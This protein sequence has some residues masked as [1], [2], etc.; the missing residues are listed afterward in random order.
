MPSTVVVI[1]ALRVDFVCLF[2][3]TCPIR[4]HTFLGQIRIAHAL[5]TCIAR[6]HALWVLS[7]HRPFFFYFKST[8]LNIVWTNCTCSDM[9]ARMRAISSEHA[10]LTYLEDMFWSCTVSKC[11]NGVFC[12]DAAH[13]YVTRCQKVLKY[14]QI[15]RWFHFSIDLI[16]HVISSQN[17]ILQNLKLQTECFV[18]P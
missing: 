6:W 8:T 13:N 2:S 5:Q 16:A 1:C 7:I 10:Q 11:L 14:W 18:L 9:T 4:A 12:P 15:R 17:K 3:W